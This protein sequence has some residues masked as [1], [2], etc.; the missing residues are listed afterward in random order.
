MAT[1]EP[2][3][4][5]V[6]VRFCGGAAGNRCLYPAAD[7]L[8]EDFVVACFGYESSFDLMGELQNPR[9]AYARI[10]SPRLVKVWQVSKCRELAQPV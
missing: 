3:E 6:H 10:V 8:I 7:P 4:R 9:A 2:D 1:D 5:V